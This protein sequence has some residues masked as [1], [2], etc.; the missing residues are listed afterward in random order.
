EAAT[1]AGEKPSAQPPQ[2]EERS[3]GH[4]EGGRPEREDRLAEELGH[5]PQRPCQQRWVIEVREREVLGVEEVVRLLRHQ[6]ERR[7]EEQAQQRESAEPE[8]RGP[9]AQR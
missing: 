4:E 6:L 5:P 2:R 8:E 9:Q 3:G 1:G 7:G